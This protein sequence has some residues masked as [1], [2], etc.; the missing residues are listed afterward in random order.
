M[1]KIIDTGDPFC[2]RLECFANR[3]TG[4]C[5]C[6]IDTHFENR[7]GKAEGEKCPFFKVGED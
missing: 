4:H 2:G 5:R 1:G 6:L 7:G 3:G